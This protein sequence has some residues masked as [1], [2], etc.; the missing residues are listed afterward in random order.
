MERLK[1]PSESPKKKLK[2][3]VVRHGPSI[4]RQPEW[5]DINTADDLNTVGRY[6]D[7]SITDEELAKGKEEAI[8]IVRA[9]AEEIADNI[10]E[11]EEVA[12]WS[13][14]TGRTLETARIIRDVLSERGIQVRSK[15]NASEHGVKVFD[16]IG[17]VKNFSWELFEPLMSGGEVEFDGE[18]FTI[19]K[20]LSNPNNIGYPDYFTSDAIKDIPE[21][22]MDSWSKKYIAQI[23]EFESF[24]DVSERM[25]KTLQKVKKLNDKKY[26]IILVTHDALTGALVKTFSSGEMGGVNPGQFLSL[27][28]S[29]NKLV[30]TRVGDVFEGD[31]ETDVAK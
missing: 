30:V 15:G 31:S 29:D 27:E 26:R 9:S 5:S 16:R 14:P 25:S 3:D 19:D 28:R 10:E 6:E 4:Y 1:Q 22:A 12:I 21:T 7:G 24:A 23:K 13:S 17:E 2:V 18:K 8:A 20:S 11:D